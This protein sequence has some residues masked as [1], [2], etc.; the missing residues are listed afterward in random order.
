MTFVSFL[1]LELIDLESRLLLLPMLGRNPLICCCTFY[2]RDYVQPV[3]REG[4]LRPEIP[5]P[6][7]QGVDHKPIKPAE[8]KSVQ[9]N[10]R[11]FSK[12]SSLG[13]KSRRSRR[14]Y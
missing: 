7:V 13:D 3:I 9:N 14:G 4:L 2:A 10:G 8:G 6:A 5:S 1:Q 11:A 12:L